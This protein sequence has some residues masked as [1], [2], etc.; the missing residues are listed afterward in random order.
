MK[1]GGGTG[2]PHRLPDQQCGGLHDRVPGRVPDP[3]PDPPDP[4]IFGPPG[5][6]Y[7]YHQAQ[8]VR[9]A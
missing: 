5:S 6:G 9:K 2:A 8:I 7:F 1:E 3:N 4:H